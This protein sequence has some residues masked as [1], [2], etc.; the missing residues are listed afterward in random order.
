MPLCEGASLHKETT[1]EA[2]G[3][4]KEAREREREGETA[5]NCEAIA[6][7]CTQTLSSVF[8]IL[9][10]GILTILAGLYD[11][12]LPT[13]MLGIICARFSVFLL[14]S[15]VEILLSFTNFIAAIFPKIY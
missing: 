1:K 4:A 11:G 15:N 3:W 2:K 14:F 10:S 7:N 6:I 12:I 9:C 8:S 5:E 13:V